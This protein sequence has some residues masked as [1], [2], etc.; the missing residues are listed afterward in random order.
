LPQMATSS[1]FRASPKISGLE[2]PLSDP[3]SQPRLECVSVLAT[4]YLLR[5]ALIQ[6]T[7]Q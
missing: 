5:V 1:N 3:Q 2:R 6:D 7:I 4:L